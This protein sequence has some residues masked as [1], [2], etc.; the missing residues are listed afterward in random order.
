MQEDIK[1]ELSKALKKILA[2]KPLYKITIK[3]ITDIVGINR[4]TFYYHFQD[5]YDLAFYLFNNELN[6]LL[7]D[8]HLI[9]LTFYINVLFTYVKNNRILFLNAVSNLDYNTM[10]LYMKTFVFKTVEEVIQVA[11]KEYNLNISESDRK[12]LVEFYGYYISGELLDWFKSGKAEIE[13]D[14]AKSIISLIE[15]NFMQN[16]ISM[17]KNCKK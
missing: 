14:K 12:N 17:S 13:D 16:I 8:P 11:L 2:N 7:K 15:S 5:I 10:L 1:E 9:N 4:Q 6:V 3:E